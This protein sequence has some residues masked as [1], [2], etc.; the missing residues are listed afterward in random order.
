MLDIKR[1]ARICGDYP[2]G[3]KF[4]HVRSCW[5]TVPDVTAGLTALPLNND[6]VHRLPPNVNVPSYRRDG[7]RSA[8]VHLGVGGF[9]RAHLATYLDDLCTLG[10]RDW[11]IAGAGTLPQ[12]R[13]MA[14]V[15]HRQDGLYT[16]IDR[17]AETTDV[18]VIGSLLSYELAHPDPT[19][20]IALIAHADTQVVSL[21]VTEG[22]YPV[23]DATGAYLPDS[24]VAGPTS[25]FGLI[26]AGLDLRRRQGG[27]PLTVLSCDNIMTNGDVA[28]AATLGETNRLGD[29]L[30]A[31]VDA[32]VAFPNGMVDRITPATTDADR[33]WLAERHSIAD[34]WPVVAEPFRQWALE[35]S[36]GGDRPPLDDV[37]VIFTSDVEPYELMKLRLL[38]ASHSC[39]A[40]LSAALTH[41]FVHTAM[42][43]DAIRSYVRD[44]LKTE[45]APA[46]PPVAGIDIADY[47]R[48][49]IDRYSNPSIADQISRLCLD[50]SA[51]F[52]KFLVPTIRAQLEVGGPIGLSTLGL[53]GW[54]HYL[55]GI[56]ED[57]SPIELAG[58]PH[59][60]EALPHVEASKTD[61]H[62]F[63]RYRRVFGADLPGN[64]RFTTA[65]ADALTSLRVNG[66][67]STIASTLG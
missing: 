17:G 34:G 36:F 35:D 64:E 50:G 45:A 7:L 63:L 4:W 6:T 47:Q 32:N 60:A 49:L 16:L 55:G 1:S 19:G 14:D 62:H 22:G 28:R 54:C 2:K 21:T 38:N 33:T 27:T 12:D 41:R 65:F 23:D 61:P 44:F 53:A 26:A 40:Y 25:A 58:D 57:G 18:R 10:R 29:D 37:G 56:A 59:L 42:S 43:D 39:L 3:K 67:R 24:A 9:H 20:L 31:W 8:V 51:K 66:V 46:L 15:L 30:T 11:A 5:Y 13:R 52:P 48:A